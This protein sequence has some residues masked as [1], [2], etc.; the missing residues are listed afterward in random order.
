MM[1]LK[2]LFEYISMSE[3]ALRNVQ[4]LRDYFKIH[5]SAL[6]AYSGGVD[7]SVLAKT[8]YDSLGEKALAVTID[9]PTIDRTELAD[10]KKIAKHIGIKHVILRDDELENECFR[11]NEPDRCY[12]C[13]KGI[14][15]LM[16]EYAKGLG[17]KAVI[18]GTNAEEVLGHRPGYK[19]VKESGALSPLAELGFK[20]QDV[21]E[22]AEYMG[23]PNAQ[24]PSMACLA[25]RIPYGTRI[26]KELLDQVS[27]A[28]A[29]VR[30]EAPR[31][32]QLRIRS[33]DELAVI[34]VPSS[35][36]Q[37]ILKRGTAISDKLKRLGYKRVVLDL[38]GYISGRISP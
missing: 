28:E 6:V 19:A 30:K 25:S 32:K 27:K 3:K 5:S 13:K 14:I 7:S 23:L 38:D 17:I 26:T 20:K 31:V 1:E 2:F 4:Q 24:K 21:R 15:G 37:E 34:E 11:K 8:A 22:M 18:E 16:Q 10:A 12:H 35:D 9:S 36:F 33:I 29:A